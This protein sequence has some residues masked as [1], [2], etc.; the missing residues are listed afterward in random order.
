MSLIAPMIASY[1]PSSSSRNA[2]ETP[3][4]IIALAAAA[5]PSTNPTG[6]LSPPPLPPISWTATSPPIT[7]TPPANPVHVSRFTGLA[8]AHRIGTPPSVSP[9]KMLN[10][11]QRWCTSAKWITLARPPIAPTAPTITHPSTSSIRRL[12]RSRVASETASINSV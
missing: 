8:I 10:I 6:P 3:G 1:C 4:R 7:I 12:K 2:P 9:M 5:P 11:T